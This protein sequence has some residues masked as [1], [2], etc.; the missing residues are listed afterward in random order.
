MNS[1]CCTATLFG[2]HPRSIP[3]SV[4]ALATALPHCDPTSTNST[5]RTVAALR[6]TIAPGRR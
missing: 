2:M 4:T 1:V 3:V 6:L 5:D